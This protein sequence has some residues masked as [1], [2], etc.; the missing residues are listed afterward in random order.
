LAAAL[1]AVVLFGARPAIQALEGSSH[2]DPCGRA[3]PVPAALRLPSFVPSGEPTAIERTMLDYL[4]SYRYRDLGWCVDKSLRDTGPYIHHLSYGVHPTV[5]I[6]YSPEVMDWL[7][8]GRRGMPRDGAVI[9]KE[10][11]P[12][13]PAIAFA[14]QSNAQLRPTDWTIMIRRSSATH[15]GWFWGELYVGMF[16]AQTAAG[17]QYPS[18]GFGIYCL[19]CHAS[20]EKA[21]TFA[22]LENIQGYPGKPL[23]Y[24]VDSSWRTKPPAAAKAAAPEKTPVPL[25]VQTFP[26]ETVDTF[27]AH[28][29]GTH[30]FVTSDQCMS[31]H[32]AALKKPYGPVMAVRALNLSEYGEWRWSPMALAGRDPVFYSQL[33]SELAYLGTIADPHAR[34]SMQQQITNVCLTCHGVMGKRSFAIDHPHLAFTPQMIFDTAPTHVG[35]H[36][37]GLARDGISC[38]V[39]HHIV[40]TRTPAGQTPLAYF[41][42]HKINGRYDLGAP[43][44]LYGPFKDNVI[45]THA[46]NVALGVKPRYSPYITSSRLC[47]SCH[48]INLP[49]INAAAQATALTKGHNVEQATYLEW[50]NSRY[51]NEYG[52]LPGAKSCQDCHMPAGITDPGRA[53]ALAHIATKIALTQDNSAPE[54]THAASWNDLNV[55]VRKTG[56]RRHELLGLNAFLMTL[57]KQFPDVMGVRT[58]DFMTGTSDNLNDAIAHVV[59]QARA[60]TAKV[61]VRTRVTGHKLIADVEVIN[62]TG[63]RFPSGVGFRRAFLDFEVRDA[64]APRAAAI[65]ASGITDGQGRIVGGNRQPLP[66]EFFQTTPGGNEFQDHFDE[67]HPITRPNQVQIFEELMRDHTGHITMSFIRRVQDIKDNRLLPQGWTK[68]GPTPT[69][70]SYFLHA[71]YPHGRAAA[72]PRYRDGKGHAI[73]RYIVTLPAGVDPKRVRVSA[74]LYYQSWEPYYLAQRTTGSGPAAQRFAALIGHVDL[75]SSALEGWK[76]RIAGASARV[77]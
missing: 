7:R 45:V 25:A 27:L 33:E 20:A 44:R 76:I 31:C 11:Y 30:V 63:H 54:T 15:D 8:N 12:P 6:Y 72:D 24:F 37:G 4:A 61:F 32:G 59:Q 62:L 73:V 42:N 29:H 43:E 58:T 47:A 74:V 48:T 10:Q 35:Y 13:N 60:S 57:F 51:Q 26:P 75:H 18:A 23:H 70:P 28:A 17:T 41:L 49:V 2:S 50:L 71:T 77:R 34:S 69:M 14:G 21:L 19:R 53:L 3:L 5:R 52:A 64:A 1:I 36:Y 67:A 38:T 22:S 39:C 66:S 16:G 68:S 9:I 65:F 46:M 40:E 56:F 55:R